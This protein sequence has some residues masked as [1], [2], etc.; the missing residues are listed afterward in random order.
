MLETARGIKGIAAA[1]RH[2]AAIG[3]QAGR[4][5]EVPAAAQHRGVA[6]LQICISSVRCSL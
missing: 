2:L 5:I 4:G 1:E 6:R 3:A